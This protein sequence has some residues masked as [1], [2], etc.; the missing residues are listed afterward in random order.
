MRRKAFFESQRMVLA[1]TYSALQCSVG[2][3]SSGDGGGDKVGGWGLDYQQ[4]AQFPPNS[5]LL[6]LSYSLN[7]LLSVST[8]VGRY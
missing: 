1:G 5:H 6:N 8:L 3:G 4:Q 7:N 2:G